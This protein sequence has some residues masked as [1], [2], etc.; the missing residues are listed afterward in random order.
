MAY[1]KRN[2]TNKNNRQEFNSYNFIRYQ[3]DIARNKKLERIFWIGALVLLFA[4][5]ALSLAGC[6]GSTANDANDEQT[7]P[8]VK[9]CFGNPD[10]IGPC[11]ETLKF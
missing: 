7:A 9:S 8:Y 2:R 4:L 10:F 1:L 11:S 3:Q 5:I 6:G